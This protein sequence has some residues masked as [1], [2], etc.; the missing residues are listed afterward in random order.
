VACIL[1]TA[2]DLSAE[3]EKTHARMDRINGERATEA[4]R[5]S[6][7]VMGISNALVDL[8]M[9]PIQDILQL[10]KSAREVLPAAGLV[11]VHLHE[12][13]TFGAAPWD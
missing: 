5:L 6:Q 13:M 3:L 2:R 9:L 8:G 1:S 12:A 11:L 4:G 10:P 7:L